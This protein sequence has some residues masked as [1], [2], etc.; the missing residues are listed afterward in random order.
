MTSPADEIVQIVD[1]ENRPI[2]TL[3]RA[4]MRQQGLIHRASYILVFNATGQIYI[5]KRTLSKDIYPG[6]WDIAAGGVVLADES[7]DESAVRELNEELG[8]SGIPLTE[9][10]DHYYEAG[11][12]KVWGRIYRCCHEGPFVLQEEEVQYGRFAAIEEIRQLHANEPFT[13]DGIQILDRLQ[14]TPK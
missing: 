13:P 9:L 1:R 8:I 6:F 4:I 7:Y 2:D 3:P 12:N 10:F 5:Q 11:E 14:Q